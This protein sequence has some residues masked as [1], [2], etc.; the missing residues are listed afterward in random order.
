MKIYDDSKTFVVDAELETAVREIRDILAMKAPYGNIYKLPGLNDQFRNRYG[1]ILEEMSGPVHESIKDNRQR[2][3]DELDQLTTYK[4]ECDAKFRQKVIDRFGELTEKA[5]S[6]NNVASLKNIPVEA[7][8]LKVRFLN[9][10]AHYIVDITPPPEEG[11]KPVDYQNIAA[12]GSANTEKPVFSSPQ[13]K[14]K[15]KKVYSLKNISSST[16]W[17]IETTEDV[18]EY[19][20]ALKKKLNSLLEENTIV[21]I[22]L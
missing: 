3:L 14:Q 21:Q 2:V 4:A 10:I 18:D 15:E 16:S 5:N 1:T 6:C 9:D 12:Q 22:E 8:A 17:Q 20:D 7:D 19:V 13:Q 11:E